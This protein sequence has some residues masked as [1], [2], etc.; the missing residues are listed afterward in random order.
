MGHKMMGHT[1]LFNPLTQRKLGGIPRLIGGRYADIIGT[2]IV[3]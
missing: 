2:H 1:S 3:N